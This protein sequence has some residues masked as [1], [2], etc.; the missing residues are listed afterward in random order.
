MNCEVMS[1]DQVY[2]FLLHKERVRRPQAEGLNTEPWKESYDLCGAGRASTRPDKCFE[3]NWYRRL[4]N[5]F[6]QMFVMAVCIA[7]LEKGRPW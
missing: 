7:L 6:I 5:H 3:S 4:Y 2:R 1:L